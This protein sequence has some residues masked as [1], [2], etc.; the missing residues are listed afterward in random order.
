[1]L[2][3]HVVGSV[4]R[5]RFLRSDTAQENDL[6]CVTGD[7]GAA[8]LGLTMLEREKQVFDR[9]GQEDYAPDFG[10]GA[11]SSPARCAPWRGTTSAR[12]PSG[13]RY[14]PRR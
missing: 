11:T 4:E 10:G 3:T 6:I 5:G 7:L 9:M 2:S 13:T 1:M 12:H 14:V 8:F